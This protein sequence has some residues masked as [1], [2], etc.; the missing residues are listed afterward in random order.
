M[1]MFGDSESASR[2]TNSV[3]AQ[4]SVTDRFASN[5]T[6]AEGVK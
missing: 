6:V 4:E 3:I 1:L 5:A 2:A